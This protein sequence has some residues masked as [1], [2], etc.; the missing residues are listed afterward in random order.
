MLIR[1]PNSGFR[2]VWRLQD[3]GKEEEA[4][5]AAA[6]TTLDAIHHSAKVI[7]LSS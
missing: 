7:H 3:E 5:I 6:W 4:I 1:V 2:H